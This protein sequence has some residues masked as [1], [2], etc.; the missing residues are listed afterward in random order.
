MPPACANM[1]ETL[2]QFLDKHAEKLSARHLMFIEDRGV[3]IYE[4]STE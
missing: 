2:Q 1:L 4:V 3:K